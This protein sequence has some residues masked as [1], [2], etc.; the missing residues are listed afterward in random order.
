MDTLLVE[1][2]FSE[3]ISQIKLNMDNSLQLDEVCD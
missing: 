1:M 2:E 3:A